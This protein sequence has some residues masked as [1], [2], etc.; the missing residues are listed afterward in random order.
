MEQVGLIG[1]IACFGLFQMNEECLK[2]YESQVSKVLK[3]L[4][5][6]EIYLVLFLEH[7]GLLTTDFCF[8]VGSGPK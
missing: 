8:E 4:S 6:M 7:N 2:L 5:K 3:S 1:L